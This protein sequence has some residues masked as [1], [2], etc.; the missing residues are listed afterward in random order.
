MV[1]H[2]LIPHFHFGE[3]APAAELPRH[4]RSTVLLAL[5]AH[6]F[7]DGVAIGSGFALSRWLGWV[8]F[9]AVLLHKLPEGV[10]IVSVMLAAGADRRAALNA[11]LILGSATVVGVL[12]IDVA[13]RLA[14]V[15]LPLASGVTLYVAATDLLPEINRKPNRRSAAMTLVGIAL[16]V[17][18]RLL[19]PS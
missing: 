13:P 10:T 3:P 19:I 5:T 8:V 1:E 4:T 16:F 14:T 15:G 7:F 17:L 18:L 2:T 12:V 9:L 11:A 6:T